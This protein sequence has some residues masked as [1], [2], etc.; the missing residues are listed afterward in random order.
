M[1]NG[2]N[3]RKACTV[4]EIAHLNWKAQLEQGR[5]GALG[6]WITPDILSSA[7]TGQLKL[8]KI[9]PVNFIEPEEVLISRA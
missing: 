1:L 6:T 7:L 5:Y 2:M 3:A 8:L 4:L 9:D